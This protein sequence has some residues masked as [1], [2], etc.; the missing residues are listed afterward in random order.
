MISVTPTMTRPTLEMAAPTP[1][2]LH[3]KLL[4]ETG[5]NGAYQE[6]CLND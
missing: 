4:T 1:S 5:E 6:I 3:L 2:N